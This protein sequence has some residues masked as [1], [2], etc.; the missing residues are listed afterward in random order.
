MRNRYKDSDRIH[1]RDIKFLHVLLLMKETP[2]PFLLY[3]SL[4]AVHKNNISSSPLTN[5]FSPRPETMNHHKPTRQTGPGSSTSAPNRGR[6]SLFSCHVDNRQ[7]SWL[8]RDN[9]DRLFILP[10]SNLSDSVSSYVYKYLCYSYLQQFRI[11]N[12]VSERN[13]D[14]WTWVN[15][16]PSFVFRHFQAVSLL[17][18]KMLFFVFVFFSPHHF[19]YL[20]ESVFA[21]VKNPL[22]KERDF[23]S[24]SFGCFPMTEHSAAL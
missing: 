12:K 14:R 15:I 13:F 22:R 7:K 16:L 18:D 3:K 8:Q 21:G 2:S 11:T 23:L 9:P 20:Y 4:T 5:H 19:W 10:T 6:T 17:S 1:R 24:R